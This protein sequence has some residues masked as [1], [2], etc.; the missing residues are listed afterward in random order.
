MTFL[1][2]RDAATGRPAAP[3]TK[4]YCLQ[5]RVGRVKGLLGEAAHVQRVEG[6]RAGHQEWIC[7]YIGT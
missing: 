7:K 6:G 3:G 1:G 5:T 2:R 4:L